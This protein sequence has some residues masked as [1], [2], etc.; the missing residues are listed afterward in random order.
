MYFLRL[1]WG[2]SLVIAFPA[3]LDMYLELVF[4]GWQQWRGIFEDVFRKLH[5]KLRG[6]Q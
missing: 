3:L 4:H 2:M 5:R 6:A 1:V